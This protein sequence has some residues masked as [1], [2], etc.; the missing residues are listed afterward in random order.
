MSRPMVCKC[1][2]D[3]FVQFDL[4]ISSFPGFFNY[5][6]IDIFSSIL[7][8]VVVQTYILDCSS[9]QV[10]SSPLIFLL[11]Y[12]FLKYFH[13]DMLHNLLFVH[14]FCVHNFCVHHFCVHHFCVHLY[15]QHFPVSHL[16]VPVHV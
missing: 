4:H 11:H 2:C 6:E 5:Q 3:L 7:M 14:H 15:V 12:L 8:N 1:K 13:H 9:K 16:Y 10:S